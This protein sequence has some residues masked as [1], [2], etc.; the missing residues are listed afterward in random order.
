MLEQTK[1][2]RA[3]KHRKKMIQAHK[4][5]IKYAVEELKKEGYSKAEVEEEVNKAYYNN[6]K[7]E[8]KTR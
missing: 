3:V 8:V 5:K 4:N 6:Q 2:E 7:I 1:E